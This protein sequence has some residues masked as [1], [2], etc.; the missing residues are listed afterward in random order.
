M[1]GSICKC[2]LQVNDFYM[3][4]WN[5]TSSHPTPNNSESRLLGV[6]ARG[7]SEGSF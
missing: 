5:F 4:V 3:K 7:A 6:S 2:A 1:G